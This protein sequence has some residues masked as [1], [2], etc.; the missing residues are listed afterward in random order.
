REGFPVLDGLRPFLTGARCLLDYRDFR[1]RKAAE[2][3]A[4][5]PQPPDPELVQ[6][7]SRRLA[8]GA[9][10]NEFESGTLLKDFGIPVNTAVPVNDGPAALVAA[11]QLGYPVALKSAQPGLLHKTEKGGVRLGLQDEGELKEAYDEMSYRLGP[12]L[13]V[14]RM[15]GGPGIEMLLGVVRDAQF[16]PLVMLGFGGIL[17]E[18][19]NDVICALPPFP[20]AAARR[21]VN[22]LKQRRLL[23]GH[24]GL[25]PADIDSFC[26]AAASLSVLA[27]ALGDVVAEIDIN[28]VLVRAD[29][30]LALDA[31]VAGHRKVDNTHDV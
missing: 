4:E 20:P 5:V 15:A 24:R 12:A 9:V 13:L 27:V 6:A 11:G 19:M 3:T 23:D 26:A 21:L 29:G 22:K 10:L 2:N 8:D 1:Q 28:P 25:P 18:S 17:V 30:C 7:W 16:G 31:L 14:S